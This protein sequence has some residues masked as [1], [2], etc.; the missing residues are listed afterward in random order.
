MV[1]K[2]AEICFEVSFECGNKV[3]GIYTILK[4]K[5]G[6]M[7]KKYGDNYWAIGF[8][9]PKEYLNN[10]EEKK[11][12]K[13]LENI[14]SELEKKGVKCYYGKWFQ[15]NDVNLILIDS[16]EFQKKNVNS[17][18]K[19]FWEDYGIDSI[20]VGFDF[21]EPFAWSYA[22]GL[23]IEKMLEMKGFK[24]KKSVAQFHEWLSG[25]GLLYLKKKNAPVGLVFTTHA[26]RIGRAKSGCGEN[27]MKEVNEGLK[28]GEYF[29]DKDAYK[30]ELQAQHMM[31]MSTAK[32]SDIFTT[33]SDIVKKEA[34]YILK[35]TPEV[36][37]PNALDLSGSFRTRRLTILHENYREKIDKFLDAYFSPYYPVKMKDNMITFISGRYEFLNKGVDLYINALK[38]L[39]KRLKERKCEKLVFAFILIPA[40]I[41]GPKTSVL[42]NLVHYQKMLDLVKEKTNE[43]TDDVVSEMLFHKK[44]DIE[45]IL[46]EDFYR[47]MKI[48]S[49][50]FSK[51]QGK[52][53][54]LC[55]YQLDYDEKEDL[56]IKALQEAGLTNKE[57]DRVKII[58]YPTYLSPSDGLLGLSY[59]EFVIGASVGVFPSR[60]EPWGYT[61]FET[62]VLRTLSVTTD[63]AGFGKFILKNV[64]KENPIKVLHIMDRTNE[65]TSAELADILEFFVY[66]E[67]E[68]KTRMKIKTREVVDILD[69][70]VQVVNYF[71][72]HKMAIEKMLSR[73]D[74]NG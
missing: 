38:K 49:N 4:S 8:Y 27:L 33:V 47:D 3:G 68:S 39:N 26:T 18:K 60:Y 7:K 48:L 65:Q 55:T 31:E 32:H 21:D 52:N 61:P 45:K 43:I 72:A 15:A 36:V 22:A 2:E 25:S 53:P 37:A 50:F 5:S 30:Y 51:Y 73:T 54:P 29:D 59:K 10:F 56:I 71:N 9:N 23:L 14:F 40:G 42:G 74:K 44:I 66:M 17:L 20:K 11:T 24:G 67:K 1:G 69:W 46:G 16:S 62:A 34:T 63:V 12:P 6:E 64:P 35:R 58:F 41:K 70:K 19:E 28:K 57:E 13:E